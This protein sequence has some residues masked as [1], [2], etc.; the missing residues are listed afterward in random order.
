[1]FKHGTPFLAIRG[2]NYIIFLDQM[3]WE[4]VLV[5]WRLVSEAVFDITIK[6][7]YNL[8]DETHRCYLVILVAGACR[9]LC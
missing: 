9:W 8:T 7:R 1:M 5:Q 6:N 3:Q 2:S 4:P